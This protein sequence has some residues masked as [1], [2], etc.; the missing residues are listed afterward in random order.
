MSLGYYYVLSLSNHVFFTQLYSKNSH[1]T[2][3]DVCKA[4]GLN[5]LDFKPN[6][7]G[8]GEFPKVFEMFPIW[9]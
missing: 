1:R 2:D 4:L 7:C 9:E 5:Y 6:D 3:Q 8:Y